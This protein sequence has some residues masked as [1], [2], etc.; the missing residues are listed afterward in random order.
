MVDG[1]PTITIDRDH[2]R[3][4]L[5][6]AEQDLAEASATAIGNGA[7][8]VP[9]VSCTAIVAAAFAVEPAAATELVDAYLES[10]S[11]LC[12]R[13]GLQ[14]PT[15]SDVIDGIVREYHPRFHAAV[16]LDELR[17]HLASAP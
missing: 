17:S 3:M 7:R 14:A 5:Q 11:E 16:D 1:M 9:G 4:L 10:L 12:R 2:Y 8:D 15:R 13:R 6:C